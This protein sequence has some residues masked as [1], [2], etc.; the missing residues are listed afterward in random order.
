MG[1]GTGVPADAALTLSAPVEH[2]ARVAVREPMVV[3]HPGGPLFVAG[4]S[5]AMEE[6]GRPPKLFRSTNGGASWEAVQVGTPDQGAVGNSDV[7]LALGPDGTLYFLTMGFDRTRGEGTHVAVGVSR[8]IGQTWEWTYLSRDRFVDRPW[9]DVAPD[10]VVHVV[11]NDGQGVRH[12]AST[13]AGETWTEW[14]RIHPLG[15]SSHLAVGPGGEIAVRITPRSASGNRYDEGVDLIAVS[16]DGGRT[17]KKRTPPGNRVWG[18]DPSDLDLLPRWVEPLAWDSSGALFHLWSQGSQLFLGRSSDQGE[19][20]ESWPVYS[21]DEPLYFPYLAAGSSGELA[22]TWFSGA[23]ESLR[24]NLA[25]IQVKD[26]LPPSMRRAAPFPIDVWREAGEARLR[27]PGGEYLPV[28]F[29]SGGDLGVVVPIQD[30]LESR[31]GFS[32]YRVSY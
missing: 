26:S 15:G 32:W 5:Q 3:E 20:W 10:G 11:W 17:W 23:G 28:L 13:D 29:L 24:A 6:S 4:F 7:D 1:E 14:P 27:D 18:N 2:L 25:L 30:V 16:G 8:D 31:L 19:R 21:A 22:A 12:A 9:I